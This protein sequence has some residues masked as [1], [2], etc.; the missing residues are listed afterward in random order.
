MLKISIQVGSVKLNTVCETPSTAKG[1]FWVKVTQVH[2]TFKHENHKYMLQV[3]T[4]PESGNY[5]SRSPDRTLR[6]DFDR[7]LL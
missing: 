2:M 5:P 4:S 1:Q 3:Q 6:S 7:K